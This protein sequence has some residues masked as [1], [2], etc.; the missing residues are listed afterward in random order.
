MENAIIFYY[1]LLQEALGG[2]KRWRKPPFVAK[3]IIYIQWDTTRI[4]PKNRLGVDSKPKYYVSSL[5]P[6]EICQILND[7]TSPNTHF[8]P[9]STINELT[10]DVESQLIDPLAK[11]TP[12]LASQ[13]TNLLASL[14][15]YEILYFTKF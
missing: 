13:S 1:K 2:E 6:L 9:L 15:K 5:K 10:N 11:A 3:W 14:K 4:Y 12:F 7:E 8:K